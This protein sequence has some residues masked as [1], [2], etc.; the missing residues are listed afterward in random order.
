MDG[1]STIV[2]L[3]RATASVA[4]AILATAFVTG[5]ASDPEP[6]QPRALQQSERSLASQVRSEPAPSLPNKLPADYF[7]PS[8]ERKGPP[9]TTGP[10]T[11]K[12]GTV[13]ISLQELVQRAVLNNKDIKATGYQPAIDQARV[14]EAQAAFD[15]TFFVN[16]QFQ[17]TDQ[18]APTSTSSLFSTPDDPIVETRS[19]STT[20]SAGIKKQM[21]TGGQIEVRA[22]T[23]RTNTA[24]N[25]TVPGSYYENQV[26]MQ[27]TQP[28]LRN[29]G[30]ETNLARVEI[31]RLNQSISALDLRKSVETNLFNLEQTYWQLVQA[32]ANV[33][34]LQDLL[35]MT[36]KT[37]DL[38]IGRMRQ[39]A[40]QVE[41]SQTL[42]SLSQRRAA[43]I[44]AKA[45]VRDLSD[46]LKQLVGD[47][48]LP[49]SSKVLILPVTP[50]TL[51][52]VQFSYDDV[53]QSALTYRLE[54]A[55]Q[56]MRVQ[57][58]DIVGKVANN[59][60]LPQLNLVG[61]AGVQGLG[62]SFSDSNSHLADGTG[63]SWALGLQFEVPIGNRAARAI[64]QRSM[65]QRQQN[66]EQYKNLIEQISLDVKVA[67]REVET[68]WQ[69]VVATREA[70]LSAAEALRLIQV[71]EDNQ[72]PLTPTFVQL[73]LDLQSALA[74]T[75]QSEA[76]A[77]TNYNI[78]IVALER[79][80]GTLL[81]YNN[82]VLEES[83]HPFDPMTPHVQ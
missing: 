18:W 10:S 2:T 58:A 47:P 28:L 50:A 46:Q 3:V 64:Y 13:T 60:L 37:S 63:F 77:I 70:R 5:C 67:H 43:I 22:Q 42:S 15:P 26:V 66:I 73:K 19:D 27:I 54:L 65:L 12:D 39:D 51:Q 74:N 81:R 76:A 7:K 8:S 55:Q 33:Q 4:A 11:Y 24:P 52:S 62:G 17:R 36:E 80:K 41:A 69:E 56:Q 68:T 38:V 32:Q 23:G 71:R 75:A 59:N 40:S 83:S 49:V 14:T 25:T 16:T 31:N 9:P 61:Q 45:K 82:V 29:F 44:R 72:E 6:F 35:A 1:N 48:D 57:S 53:L 20:A 79:A 30:S 34:I 21:E 78:S